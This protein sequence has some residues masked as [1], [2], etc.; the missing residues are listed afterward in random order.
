MA[1][2]ESARVQASARNDQV[3]ADVD[4]TPAIYGSLLV[5][6]LVAV[7]WR[8]DANPGFIGLSLATSV[9]V[10]YIAHVWAEIVNRRLRGTIDRRALD[11]VVITEASMLTA[12]V[13]PGILL[14]LPFFLG[15]P[16]DV[17]IGAA[18]LA[19]LVQLFLWGLAVGRA[20]HGTWPMAVLVG[21]VDCA[22][23]IAVVVLKVVVLH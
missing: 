2:A 22:L 9:F 13:V 14:G 17:A 10:F 16:V 8:A 3:E 20:T 21:V 23:G 5:T 11:H 7:Q 19:S 4:Y 18:L 1:E 15:V 6:T 12:V